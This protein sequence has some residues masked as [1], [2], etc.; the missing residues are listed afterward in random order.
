MICNSA[1]EIM[2]SVSALRGK[3]KRIEAMTKGL[4]MN[5]IIAERKGV[6]PRAGRVLFED[7]S[8]RRTNPTK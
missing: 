3:H 1:V 8:I 6:S 7:L 4:G 2:L 5:V